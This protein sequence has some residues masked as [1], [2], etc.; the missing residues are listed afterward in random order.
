MKRE[1]EQFLANIKH[2]AWNNDSVFIGGVEFT[3]GDVMLAHAELSRAVNSRDELV[4]VLSQL[5]GEATLSECAMSHFAP[6]TLEQARA[7]LKIAK[8]E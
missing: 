4:A 7:A 1:V 8:G 6:L 2:A 3:A 5:L